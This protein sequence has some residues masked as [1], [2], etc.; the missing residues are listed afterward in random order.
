MDGTDDV[1][2]G[3]VL[4]RAKVDDERPRPLLERAGEIGGRDEQLRIGV[5]GHW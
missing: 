3:E 1:S 4:G 2:A 5:A